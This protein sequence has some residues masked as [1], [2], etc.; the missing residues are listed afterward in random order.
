MVL[1][2]S[3]RGVESS[4][5]FSGGS[6][7]TGNVGVVLELSNERERGELGKEGAG[8][9]SGELSEPDGKRRKVNRMASKVYR[10]RCSV[11][12][13]LVVGNESEDE[14][15]TLFGINDDKAW[16]KIR[17]RI[18]MHCPDEGEN[19]GLPFGGRTILSYNKR[20][21]NAKKR[22]RLKREERRKKEVE[23]DS[24]Y[25]DDNKKRIQER[26]IYQLPGNEHPSNRNSTTRLPSISEM[27]NGVTPSGRILSGFQSEGVRSIPEEDAVAADIFVDFSRKP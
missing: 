20:R 27:I 15:K 6:M 21:M 8:G 18:F 26:M 2:P 13:R 1:L 17:S 12:N 7:G 16:D 19:E 25:E 5:S 23:D 14:V 11:A 3:Y 10:H 22:R 24:N 9:G 4:E